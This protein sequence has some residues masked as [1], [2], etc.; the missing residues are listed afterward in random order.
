M[1][2][3]FGLV[4]LLLVVNL[5]ITLGLGRVNQGFADSNQPVDV[6]TY[7]VDTD[8]LELTR[9]TIHDKEEL[10]LTTSDGRSINLDVSHLYESHLD[11]F[12]SAFTQTD[13]RLMPTDNCRYLAI[14]LSLEADNY[15]HTINTPRDDLSSPAHPIRD[16][17]CVSKLPSSQKL[18]PLYAL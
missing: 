17:Q 7:Y 12:W 4:L 1:I 15:T 3:L 13:T 14:V 10:Q 18:T 16:V 5:V 11:F 2:R 9:S 6:L 8:R